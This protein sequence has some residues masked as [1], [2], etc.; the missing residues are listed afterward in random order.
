MPQSLSITLRR[1][2]IYVLCLFLPTPYGSRA[3]GLRSWS[4]DKSSLKASQ[5]LSFSSDAH[6]PRIT[7]IPPSLAVTVIT[8]AYCGLPFF[9]FFLLS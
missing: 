9:F 2:E 7:A 8:T 3:A 1:G 5:K 4:P 6:L